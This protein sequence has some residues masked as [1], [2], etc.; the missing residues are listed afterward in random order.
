MSLMMLRVPRGPDAP[1]IPKEFAGHFRWDTRLSAR[2]GGLLYHGC[3]ESDLANALAE[4][5]LPLR[6]DW[7]VEL[8]EFGN[9]T[10]EGVWAGLNAYFG[11]WNY[12]G[13]C[14]VTLPVN[15]L[16]GHQ[17]LVFRRPSSDRRSVYTFVQHDSPLPVYLGSKEVWREV[18]PDEFFQL[19][20][21]GLKHRSD[22]GYRVVLTTSLPLKGASIQGVPHP[23]CEYEGC[24]GATAEKAAVIVERQ[25]AGVSWTS[26]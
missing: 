11:L 19:A 25:L 23:Q 12:F 21:A 6:S 14:L 10:A 22:D 26:C 9:W 4:N 17:F 24:I 13:P 16:N 20:E 3:H 18:C 7:A 2:L 1:F 15:V 5:A 8:P